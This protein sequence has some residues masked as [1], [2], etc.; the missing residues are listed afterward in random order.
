M[1]RRRHRALDAHLAA[2]RRRATARARPGS[3]AWPELRRTVERRAAVGTPAR[4]IC[5]EVAAAFAERRL[6]APSARTL[7]RWIAERRWLEGGGEGGGR[8]GRGPRPRP[9]GRRAL[10]APRVDRPGRAGRLL[11]EGLHLGCDGDGLGVVGV[12]PPLGRRD[13]D[14]DRHERE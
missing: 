5:A 8:S 2:I 4:A 14:R 7:R 1:T 12:P 9:P 10:G 6:R 11:H 13:A 3:Y